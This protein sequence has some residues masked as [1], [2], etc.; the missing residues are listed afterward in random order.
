MRKTPLVI[1]RSL[2]SLLT[3]AQ[4]AELAG[5][6]SYARG[7]DYH[8]DGRVEFGTATDDN[9]EAVVRG[10]MP[11]RVVLRVRGRTVDWSCMCP[12]GEDGSFCK[13]CV[14]VALSLQPGED[15]KQPARGRK[16]R[17]RGGEPDLRT[18]V[19]S[20]E[21]AELVDLVM[22]QAKSDWRL[23][24]RLAARAAAAAGSG[25]D[26]RLWRRRLEA[27]FAPDDD[28]VDYREAPA[29]AEDVEDTLDALEEL[30]DAGHAGAV[31]TLAEHAHHLADA[32][33]Q[34]IDD[35]DGWLTGISSHLGELH[36]RAC[37]MASPD[38]VELA[39]RLA[40]LELTAELDTF[41]RA[42]LTYADVLGPNGLAEYRRVIEPRWRKLAPDAEGWSS[43][44]FR[45]SEAM[46][47]IALAVHDPDE[48]VRVKQHDLRAPDDY[49]EVAEALRGAGRVEEAIDWAR[50]GLEAHADRPRQTPPLREL[51]AEMLRE[52]GDLKGAVAL[53]WQAFEAHPSLDAYRRLLA[54][55]DLAG[56][57][58][59]WRR[60]AMAALRKR[61]GKRPVGD[62]A[63]PPVV[64]APAVVLVEVLLH[65]GD[66]NEAWKAATTYGC[67]DR[68]WLTLARARGQDHPLDAIPVYER[69]ALAAIEG[70]NNQA[71]RAAVDRLDAIEKLAGRA[72]EPERFARFVAEVR[73][74][75]KAKRNLMALLAAR[76]W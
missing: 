28:F 32:A 40:E 4:V 64:V 26:E 21:Q 24:E 61:V 51:L 5:P 16:A 71:Y 22:E 3:L 15:T 38:P 50:R 1:A 19:A 37:T 23:H 36:L 73:V 49:R 75:H 66:V 25:I 6:R 27:A 14:A 41:H 30:A 11:Y 31:V 52:Q 45:L 43:E 9:V 29:W 10:T 20:L 39:R 44:R 70:R 7:L 46:T 69:S 60:R 63:G 62:V 33:V 58:D 68:L 48:L 8:D 53:F 74:K 2:A 57:R 72:G 17:A 13:H 59:D 18:Y 35:S 56:K 76:G 34:Y 54:E 47:G 55:A 65:E 42:A 67:T 12:V